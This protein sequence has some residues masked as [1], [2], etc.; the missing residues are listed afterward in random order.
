M[1]RLDIDTRRTQ[2]IDAAIRIALRDGLDNTTVRRIATE[3]GVSLGTVHYCFDNKR[4]LL[5]AVVETLLQREVDVAEFDLPDGATPVDAIKQAFRYYWTLSGA[6]TERQ[7][8]VYEL[9][10]YLVRQ[11]APGPELAQR[12]FANKYE[13][14][15]G[16]V[17][18]FQK[19][20]EAEL[21]LP[22]DV[23]ARM[24]VAMTDGV[25]L[26]WL[27]DGDDEK[28]LEVLDSFAEILAMTQT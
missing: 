19:K 14:V 4:A 3:A 21:G 8:L 2:L 20:G 5:E 27:A 18:L 12:I 15:R 11:E 9:V 6:Q 24:T 16:F 22:A 17:E 10:A 7:R 28:A 23:I 1:P 26:A 13:V 25:A